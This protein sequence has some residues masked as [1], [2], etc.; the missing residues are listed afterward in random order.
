MKDRISIGDLAKATDTKVETIRYYERA[1][2]LPAPARTTGNYRSYEPA[3]RTRLGFIRRAREL[4][5]SL[6]EVQDMLQLSDDK[7]RS[8]SEVDAIAR[9]HLQ[10]V[11][12]KI[13]DLT[14]LRTELRHLID[15]CHRNTIAD[16]RILD[17]LTPEGAAA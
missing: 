6:K 9:T 1:G 7:Q 16:C 10:D 2:L 14:R 15:Q 13:A 17:A 4:G 3:H 12:R 11:E 5:F 8:C